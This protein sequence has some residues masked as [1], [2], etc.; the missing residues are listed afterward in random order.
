MSSN[1]QP[2]IN[3]S[4]ERC[5]THENRSQNTTVGSLR[6][7]LFGRIQLPKMPVLRRKLPRKKRIA[8]VDKRGQY[9]IGYRG[10]QP[11]VFLKDLFITFVDMKW[12]WALLSFFALYFTVFFLFT[13][14]WAFVCW[15]HGDFGH[16]GERDYV[17]C[18]KGMDSFAGL[19]LFSIETQTSIGYGFV[20]PNT[21]CTGSL[22]VLFF[23]ITFGL[24]LETFLLTYLI[25]K[26]FRPSLRSK[27]IRFS[28]NAVICQEDGSLCLQIRVGDLRKKP[29]QSAA[30]YGVLVK[31]VVT[32]EGVIYPLYQHEIPFTV[33]CMEGDMCMMWPVLL[34]HRITSSSPFWHIKEAD[35]NS[36]KFEIIIFLEGVVE[37]TGEMCQS[38]TS[39]TQQEVFWGYRFQQLMEFDREKKRWSVDFTHFDQI[40]SFPTPLLSAKDMSAVFEGSSVL[41][42]LQF[43]G[44]L[45]D[46]I[47]RRTQHLLDTMIIA[48]CPSV[49]ATI[50]VGLMDDDQK[51][52]FEKRERRLSM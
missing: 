35:I 37:A 14:V 19:L 48:N 25:S 49:P 16:L 47:S 41:K 34:T 18:V 22:I 24:V 46:S 29:L 21:E 45:P 39:Y 30:A 17:P 33:D 2:N 9:T 1:R 20:H 26:L 52:L 13:L 28:K 36:E 12:R 6:E 44:Q 51:H 8:V 4:Y 11:L 43:S 10:R 3:A 38:R 31:E 40:K 50:P 32:Q 23:Q 5:N 27:T 42:N 15:V 7:A